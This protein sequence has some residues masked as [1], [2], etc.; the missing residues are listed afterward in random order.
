MSW[1]DWILLATIPWVGAMSKKS[2]TQRATPKKKTKSTQARARAKVTRRASRPARRVTRAQAAPT[3]GRTVTV[4]VVTSPP[5]QPSVAVPPIQ[6]ARPIGRAILIAPENEKWVD[7][8][9][10]TFRW[11][12]VGGATRYEIIWGEDPT[13]T[14][15]HTL[16]SIATEATVPLES[17]LQPGK[18]YYWRVRGGNEVGWSPWSEVHSFRVL[19]EIP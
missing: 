9:H 12:S 2:K 15:H 11:L 8:V 7:S 14:M 18:T 16:H 13:L 17:P 1:A 4:S 5:P 19:E 10:P 6:P 3:R